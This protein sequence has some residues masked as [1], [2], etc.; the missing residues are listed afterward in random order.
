M[1]VRL[2]VCVHCAC[3]CVSMHVRVSM[4][5]C[6]HVCMLA[7]VCV[8]ERVYVSARACVVAHYMSAAHTHA[9]TGMGVG[10]CKTRAPGAAAHVLLAV[11]RTGAHQAAPS[12]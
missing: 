10:V 8:F 7:S 1:C 3:V 6:V 12:G 5:V 9:S 2:R 4:H 11:G